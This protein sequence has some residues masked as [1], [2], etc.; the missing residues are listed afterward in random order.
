MLMSQRNWSLVMSKFSQNI[1]RERAK[2]TI[3]RIKWFSYTNV[4]LGLTINIQRTLIDSVGEHIGNVLDAGG[5]IAAFA[6]P[7]I[8]RLKSNGYDFGQ[9]EGFV[10]KPFE[11]AWHILVMDGK[12]YV[13]DQ[14]FYPYGQ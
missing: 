13:A 1:A 4:P 11:A 10:Q 12:C 6:I 14:E 2:A 9:S 5:A 7:H 3:D 8:D